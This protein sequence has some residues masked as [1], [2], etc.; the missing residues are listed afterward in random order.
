[1]DFDAAAT[2]LQS[3]HQTL[4]SRAKNRMASRKLASSSDTTKARRAREARQRQLEV[5]RKEEKLVRDKRAFGRS[6]V[7]RVER[8]LAVVRSL[9]SSIMEVDGV[10][11][12]GEGVGGRDDDLV[13]LE[14]TSIYGQGDK[15]TLPPS[16]L[17]SLA[18]QDLLRVSQE[19]GQ[20][21]FFRLAI[22]KQKYTFP[23][24]ASLKGMIEDFAQKQQS[25]ELKSTHSSSFGEEDDDIEQENND[26]EEEEK[27][28]EQMMKSYV[29]ELAEEYIT[30]TYST[31]VEFTQ[32]EGCIGLPPSIASALLRPIQDGADRI[33]RT[34]TVDPAT[35]AAAASKTHSMEEDG[36]ESES[37]QVAD[38]PAADRLDNGDEEGKTPGHIAYG[39][40]AVPV[41]KIEVSLLAHL[42]LGT[43]C[44]LQPTPDAIRNGFYDLKNIKL[45]LEQSLIRTRGCLN[46]NDFVHCWHRGKKFDLVVK[47]VTPGNVG[48]VS[49]VNTDIEV[50]ICAVED[51]GG[52]SEEMDDKIQNL[53]D[54]TTTT[55]STKRQGGYRLSDSIPK[56]Q[57]ATTNTD[58]GTTTTTTTASIKA[59]HK[60]IDLPTEPPTE[61]TENV[62][63]IQLRGDGGKMSPRRRF[64][65]TTTSIKHLFGYALA[66][67]VVDDDSSS[68]SASMANMVEEFHLVT[69]FPR[70]VFQLIDDGDTYLNEIDNLSKQEL[71]LVERI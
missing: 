57:P 44:S 70:R 23:S 15:I 5:R 10:G 65:T 63:M 48:A 33:E 21:L 40:F 66:S 18:N 58:I 20:P 35:A 19:R 53:E 4:R 49:C 30:Y 50:D 7:D 52:G 46:V 61:Q 47:D 24:S 60:S 42:P 39:A 54:A 36:F 69:R 9:S 55:T 1:M 38:S 62:V 28:Q 41:P 26:D 56:S 6:V 59:Q 11:N 67:Q 37:A 3:D 31:V 45:A 64:D 27:M 68:D 34:F 25:N 8:K 43:K 22:P 51:E 29:D 32:A 13:L 12:G 71:F 16:I 17:S 14:A 2:K